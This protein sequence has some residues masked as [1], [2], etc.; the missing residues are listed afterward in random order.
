MHEGF[1]NAAQRYAN[2]EIMPRKS[3]GAEGQ[4]SRGAVAESPN[5]AMPTADGE[6]VG[7]RHCFWSGDRGGAVTSCGT[8]CW[9][10]FSAGELRLPRFCRGESPWVH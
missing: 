2:K 4:R 7:V 6:F 10:F 1:G 5:N 3:R 9:I 8:S